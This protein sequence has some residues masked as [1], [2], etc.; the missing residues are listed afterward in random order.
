MWLRWRFTQYIHVAYVVNAGTSVAIARIIEIV[1]AALWFVV[2][3]DIVVVVAIEEL[4]L[5]TGQG[6]G[7]IEGT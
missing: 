7:F 1:V 6:R 3:V 2:V 4:L 5:W